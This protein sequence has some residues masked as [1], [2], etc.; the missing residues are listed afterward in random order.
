MPPTIRNTAILIYSCG[1]RTLNMTLSSLIKFMPP[2][3]PLYILDSASENQPCGERRIQDLVMAHNDRVTLVGGGRCVPVDQDTDE[4]DPQGN[5]CSYITM[6]RDFCREHPEFEY[7]WKTDDDVVYT[8]PCIWPGVVDAYIRTPNVIFAAAAMP[9]Q[10]HIF[11]II[12][13]RLGQAGNYDKALRRDNIFKP[14]VKHPELAQA[15]WDITLPPD[16]VLSRLRK[17]PDKLLQIGPTMLRRDHYIVCHY[18]TRREDVLAAFQVASNDQRG[19]HILRK[20][21]GRNIGVDMHNLAYHYSCQPGKEW[22]DEHILPRLRAM[23][24][25]KLEGNS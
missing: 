16:T 15:V 9:L 25:W 4:S 12:A 21:D 22:S 23:D 5:G 24:F 14:L 8:S 11:P 17:H 20:R 1:M 18:L 7:I 10:R 2:S 13:E 19:Y 3:L 6:L